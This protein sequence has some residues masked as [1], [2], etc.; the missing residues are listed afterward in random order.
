M[1]KDHSGEWVAVDSLEQLGLYR[2]ALELVEVIYLDAEQEEDVNEQVKALLYKLKFSGYIEEEALIKAIGEMEAI[3]KS[4]YYP[5]KPIIHSILAE[6]YWGYYQSHRYQFMERSETVN[7]Q[8]NDLRTWDLSR[9]M[10]KV[11]EHHGAALQDFTKLKRTPV[12]TILPLL[13]EQKTDRAARPKLFDLLAH[14]ALDFYKNSETGLSAPAHQFQLAGAKYFSLFEEFAFIRIGGKDTTSTSYQAIKIFQLLTL[15]HLSDSDP[16]ALGPLELERLE[17]VYDHSTH[18]A[19]DSLYLDALENLAVPLRDGPVWAEVQH[20]KATYWEKEG[21][22][23]Q[24]L[25]GNNHKWELKEASE[26]AEEAIKKF[27]NSLGARNCKALVERL[28]AEHISAEVEEVNAPNTPFRASISYRNSKLIYCRIIPVTADEHWDYGMDEAQMKR[29]LRKDPVQVAFWSPPLDGDLQQHRMEVKLDALPYGRYVMLLASNEQFNLDQ[30]IAHAEFWISDLALMSRTQDNQTVE[31]SVLHRR[32][33]QP[34]EGVVVGSYQRTYNS[35]KREYDWHLL[36]ERTTDEHGRV[37]IPPPAQY[38]HFELRLTLGEDH[39]IPGASFSQYNNGPQGVKRHVSTHFFLDRAIYRPGQTIH[40]KGIV[41][42]RE[43]KKDPEILADRQETVTLY[44][45]NNQKVSELQMTTNE[46]GTFHGSFVAPMGGLTGRMRLSCGNGSAYF[47]VEEYKRPRFEVEL[48]PVE[49]SFK[50]GEQVSITGKATSYSGAALNDAEVRYYVRREVRYPFWYWRGP[51]MPQPASEGM[52]IKN[53]TVQTAA[54]GTFQI[55]FRAIA[56]Q[57]ISKAQRPVFDY[58]VHVDVVDISGETHSADRSVSVGYDA[59]QLG[60]GIPA[61]LQQTHADSVVVS[62]HNLN[63]QPIALEGKLRI[64]RLQMPEQALRQRLWARPDTFVLAKDKFKQAFPLDVYNNENDAMEWPKGQLVLEKAFSANQ[65]FLMKELKTWKPGTYLAEVESMD[66]FGATVYE[67]Q[68]V[69][70]FDPKAKKVPQPAVFFTQVLNGSGEPGETAEVLI[71]SSEAL[72]ILFEVEVMNTIVKSQW[73]ELNKDMRKVSVPIKEEHRGNFTM[74]FSALKNNRTYALDHTVIVPRSD[75]ELDLEFETFRNKLRPGSEEEW[76]LKIKGPGGEKVAAEMLA[77]MYDASLDAFAVNNWRF[78]IFSSYYDR[79][80]WNRHYAMGSSATRLFNKHWRGFMG[81]TARVFDRLNFFGFQ[82]YSYGG[83]AFRGNVFHSRNGVTMANVAKPLAEMD[84]AEVVVEE[85][86]YAFDLNDGDKMGGH[87]QGETSEFNHDAINEAPQNAQPELNARKNLQET[88]FF[89]PDLLTDTEGNVVL[90]FTMP[91][92]LTRWK[93]LG[94]AHSKE[95]HYAL[96]E[97]EV[98]TQ[99]ELMVTPNVPRFL[100]KGDMITLSAKVSNLSEKHL[101]GTFQ[102]E[103]FDALTNEP[104]DQLLRNANPIRNFSAPQGQS[105]AEEWQ[106]E[107]PEKF[108]AITYRFTARA[109]QFADGE[110]GALPILSNRMLVTETMPLPI[111]KKGTQ[112]WRMEKLLNSEGSNTLKHHTLTFEFTSNPAWY[113]VQALPYMME[114]PYECSEQTFTRLYANSLAAHI[115]NS[116]P[117]IKAVFEQWKNASTES[118]LSAL[119]KNQELKSLMLEETPWVMEAQDQSERKRRV[120]LLFDLQR[121]EREQATAFRKL[122]EAQYDNGGWPWFPGMPESR[123]ITQHIVNGFGHMDVLGV[124]D[125]LEDPE[126]GP[127]LRKAIGYLDE[128]LLEDYNRLDADERK[129]QEH[130]SALHVQYL[131]ARSYFTEVPLRADV[132]TAFAYYKGRAEQHW[133]KQGLQLQAMIALAMHRWENPEKAQAIMRSLKERALLNE[134]MGMYWKEFYAG[135]SWYQMPVETHALMIEAFDEIMN[136]VEAVNDLRTFLL[137][138]KQTTDWKTTKATANACYAL[139]LRGNDWLVETELPTIALGGTTID[140]NDPDL[141]KDAGTGYFK[142]SWSG[143]AV[144]PEMGE[145]SITKRE[146]GVSWG[147]L[148]WQY[149]EDLD[150]ITSAETPLQLTKQLFVE[151]RSDTG[152]VLHP[153]TDTTE[154]RPGDLLKVRIELRADRNME[155]VHLKD[156]RASGLEPINVLSQY[157]WQDG[158]GY[159]ESTRDASTNFFMDFLPKGTYV[160]EYP[161]RATH[162]GDMSNGIT[163]IQCMYAPEFTAHS[164]GVRVQVGN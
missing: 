108:D 134:E 58:R 26:I 123:Y 31:I 137:K 55:D 122:R 156:M 98:I 109:G 107:V 86:A 78:D 57:S 142:K 59:V 63:G 118:F 130:I 72:T 101:E 116:N 64:H 45:V 46:Y 14:R 140:T 75:K 128:R 163:S 155:F 22:K 148:Y 68:L 36:R 39:L 120:A 160:F 20:A 43:G 104:A 44:D 95:L 34:L 4:A 106:I 10:G 2:S 152:P 144:Q 52:E 15:A 61:M 70:V 11:Y 65:K 67:K 17:F 50:L 125:A 110:E 114:Y 161:L 16:D 146:D 154:L 145:V 80:A 153:V 30:N 8:Q 24:A 136:D 48:D 32:T 6:S 124:Y 138:Q 162:N 131:Y 88:A 19:K 113:A 37:S 103:L 60:I 100:R 102:L 51:W 66:A 121:M 77:A 94:L 28:N 23:Y 69:T 38:V 92:A 25:L 33:G 119:E 159:Y 143:T 73:I 99:K 157:K 27:P 151:K 139:L 21:N 79:R 85:E 5:L 117:K 132:K 7:F 111:R 96:A 42:E 141:K 3:G 71:G 74:H 126:V 90:K 18:P 129:N 135:Y 81:D 83:Y 115:G 149:F 41:L 29:L 13:L 87:E 82:P 97:Q 133:L 127:M 150:K 62:A 84:N 49:S 147:A 1:T 158:L 105:T 112:Q 89:S 54:D 56:D 93:F 53:G 164:E 47:R 40:F 35:K 76:R 9:I 91:E 12:D